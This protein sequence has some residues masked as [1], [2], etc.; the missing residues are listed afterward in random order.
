MAAEEDGIFFFF[1][2]GKKQK[3]FNSHNTLTP[4]VLNISHPAGL[5]QTDSTGVYVIVDV[6]A[7]EEGVAETYDGRVRICCLK[8]KQAVLVGEVLVGNRDF[9]EQ[10]VNAHGGPYS[11]AEGEIALGRLAGHDGGPVLGRH[12]EQVI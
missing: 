12:L 1:P 3:N 9:G 7:A 11:E 2:K 8:A 5:G 4:R 6:G 10:H